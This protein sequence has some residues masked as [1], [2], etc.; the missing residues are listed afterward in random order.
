MVIKSEDDALR[1]PAIHAFCP[2]SRFM[3]TASR[4]QPNNRTINNVCLSSY[5]PKNDRNSLHSK[6]PIRTAI[7]PSHLDKSQPVFS[8]RRRNTSNNPNNRSLHPV[9]STQIL[10]LQLQRLL[11]PQPNP[12]IPSPMPAN[13]IIHPP[14]MPS[15]HSRTK[16]CPKKELNEVKTST[17]DTEYHAETASKQL[18][19][20]QKHSHA[21]AE[22]VGSKICEERV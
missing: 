14:D 21:C 8:S 18:H 20:E 9:Q 4:K 10:H 2:V 22:V 13:R 11:L 7:Q 17:P 6:S 3:S 15:K 1:L 12:P 16:Q 19:R 5:N